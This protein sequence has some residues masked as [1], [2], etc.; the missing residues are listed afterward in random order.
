MPYENRESLHTNVWSSEQ[1]FVDFQGVKSPVPGQKRLLSAVDATREFAIS[2]L[3]ITDITSVRYLTGFTGSAAT[4][5]IAATSQ[6]S[7]FLCTDGRYAEQAKAELAAFGIGICEVVTTDPLA[8]DGLLRKLGGPTGVDGSRISYALATRLA[9]LGLGPVN[10]GDRL[11]QLREVKDPRE[12]A[13]ITAASQIAAAAI[14][15]TI[16]EATAATTELE[17][18]GLFE[19]HLRRLGSDGPAF[20]TIV[21]AKERSSL[22]HAAPTSTPIGSSGPLLVDFGASVSGYHSDCSRTLLIGDPPPDFLTLETAV[23]KAQEA[24]VAAIKPG[25]LV[26]EVELEARRV[27]RECGVEHLLPHGVGHGVGLEIHEE[28]FTARRTPRVFVEGMTIT[29]EPGVYIPRR[30]GLRIEDLFVVTPSGAEPL[31]NFGEPL[32]R[33]SL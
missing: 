22:P 16:Q 2:S 33:L 21:A 3:F 27:L 17:F 29:V 12:V 6:P 1:P 5:A 14:D 10:I 30:F 25:S 15:A 8:P 31:T 13:L 9:D 24:G 23:R 18:V 7:A 4:L 11:V 20:P 28:P 32:R 19:Y 26:N